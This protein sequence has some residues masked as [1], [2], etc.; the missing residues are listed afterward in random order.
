MDSRAWKPSRRFY[1]RLA[2]ATNKEK[3]NSGGRPAANFELYEGLV[4]ETLIIILNTVKNIGKFLRNRKPS[5]NNFKPDLLYNFI[6]TYMRKTVPLHM[7]KC[8]L[9]ARKLLFTFD[10]AP[11]LFRFHFLSI[12]MLLKTLLGGTPS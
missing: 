2:S 10:F 3:N 11:N 7:F 4:Y 1:A 12:K 5:S 9:N 8:L 6:F